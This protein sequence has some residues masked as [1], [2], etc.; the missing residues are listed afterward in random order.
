MYFANRKFYSFFFFVLFTVQL[1]ILYFQTLPNEFD[2]IEALKLP[3]PVIFMIFLAPLGNNTK[4]TFVKIGFAI[5]IIHIFFG[6]LL[7]ILSG[8]SSFFL[9]DGRF[10]ILALGRG[11]GETAWAFCALIVLIE[12][13]QK[14]EI[15]NIR[16]GTKTIIYLVSFAIIIL[17]QARS[18]LMFLLLYYYFRSA[19]SFRIKKKNIWIGFLLFV[20]I[21]IIAF[22]ADLMVLLNRSLSLSSVLTGREYIWFAKLSQLASEDFY[23]VLFG[24]DLSPKIIEVPEIGYLTADPHN[25][26][27][28]FIQ[29]Y[30][31]F[32]LLV[33]GLWYAHMA[34][35]SSQEAMPI[36]K[37][38]IVMSLFVSSFRYSSVFYINIVLLILPMIVWETDI[39]KK[40][41]AKGRLS[42]IKEFNILS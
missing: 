21:L 1:C 32:F 37:A 17:T 22:S 29:Y 24:S 28:D 15:F 6:F 26:Y 13:F 20:V 39:I 35:Y 27:L 14:Q 31:L 5:L 2:I 9:D 12:F 18:A 23:V 40:R 8:F 42:N 34:K 30:G 10:V 33:F 11:A 38:F 25:L 41:I 3:S 36:L 4:I 19:L 7:G 16:F